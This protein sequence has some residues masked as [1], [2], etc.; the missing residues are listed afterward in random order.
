MVLG[1]TAAQ[2]F[3]WNTSGPPELVSDKLLVDSVIQG[4]TE[5]QLITRKIWVRPT[6]HHRNPYEGAF[7][8]E[9]HASA[10][11]FHLFPRYQAN[12]SNVHLPRPQC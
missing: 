5:L 2:P 6:P 11:G 12:D 4:L 8:A 1:V 3:T 7:L 10:S 9:Y